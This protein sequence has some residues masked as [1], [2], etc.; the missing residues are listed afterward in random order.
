MNPE[1]IRAHLKR[2]QKDYDRTFNRLVLQWVLLNA[3][4]LGIILIVRRFL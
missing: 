3:A 1:D 4:L 2:A